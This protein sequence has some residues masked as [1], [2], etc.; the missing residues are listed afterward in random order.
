MSPQKGAAAV[1]L[2]GGG[3]G[4]CQDLRTTMEENC[5]GGQEEKMR[6]AAS[7]KDGRYLYA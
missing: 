2:V 1:H 7:A 5:E 6:N 4:T 3:I